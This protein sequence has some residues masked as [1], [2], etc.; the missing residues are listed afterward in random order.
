MNIKHGTC[1]KDYSWN[2]STCTS[3]NSKYLKGFI[4][5]SVSECDEVII[6]MDK[7]SIKKTN[8]IATNVTS[9]ASIKRHSNKVRDCYILYTVLLATILLLIVIIICYHYTKQ[10]GT[11]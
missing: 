9:T 1:K 4:D 5:N 11:I 3:E 7:I 10:K 8:T 6:V 2:P